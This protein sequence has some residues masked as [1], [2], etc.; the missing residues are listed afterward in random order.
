MNR[1]DRRVFTEKFDRIA[2]S[3]RFQMQMLEY[4][5]NPI[6]NNEIFDETT[7]ISKRKITGVP[8]QLQNMIYN[9]LNEHSTGDIQSMKMQL[10]K[11]K[12]VFM[13]VD[14]EMN[15]NMIDRCIT[16]K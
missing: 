10:K 14:Q 5:M 15:T 6:D 16:T 8:I 4:Q 1:V 13:M 7:N 2:R 3:S 11:K 12:R 9:R